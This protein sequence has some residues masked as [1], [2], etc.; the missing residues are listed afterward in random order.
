MPETREFKFAFTVSTLT[1]F[2]IS[3]VSLC[4]SQCYVKRKQRMISFLRSL[5]LPCSEEAQ[6][7]KDF[8]E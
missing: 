8:V 1:L 4:F 7:S 3:Y 5:L 6:P 2:A